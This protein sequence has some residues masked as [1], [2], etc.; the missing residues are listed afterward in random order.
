MAHWRQPVHQRQ[1]QQQNRKEV[2]PTFLKVPGAAE[3]EEAH[4][5]AHIEIRADRIAI[6]GGPRGA[7][8]VRCTVTLMGTIQLSEVVI[9]VADIA[10][11]LTVTHCG[12]R[13]WH[14]TRNYVI[15]E[16]CGQLFVA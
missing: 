4:L 10:V 12:T 3:A 2:L 9:A 13:L 5:A 16:H 11:D 6:H 14:I 15:K 1:Q 7:A 8:P